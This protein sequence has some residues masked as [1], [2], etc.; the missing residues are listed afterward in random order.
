M[1]SSTIKTHL[2]CSTATVVLAIATLVCARVFAAAGALHRYESETTLG[3]IVLCWS[4]DAAMRC[5]FVT[6]SSEE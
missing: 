3:G 4:W 6:A 2:S 5:C 1:T